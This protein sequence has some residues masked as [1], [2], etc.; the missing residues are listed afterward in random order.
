MG[1]DHAKHHAEHEKNADYAGHDAEHKE[2]AEVADHTDSEHHTDHHSSADSDGALETLFWARQDSTKMNFTE[3]EVTFM[4]DM[5]IHHSQALV[6]SELASKNGAG[7]A[8]S[9]LASRIINAQK[10]EIATMQ[11]WLRERGQ[12]VPVISIDGIIMT[13]EFEEPATS[14]TADHSSGHEMSHKTSKEEDHSGHSM[15][16][17]SMTKTDSS[18]LDGHGSSKSP[19]AGHTDHSD[20]VGMLSQAQLEELR[21]AKGAEFDRLFLTYMIQH[22]SGAL[23]MVEDLFKMDGAG[24]VPSTFRLASDIQ[25]DQT[26]EIARMNKMLEAMKK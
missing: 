23:V 16:G 15:D 14:M 20:M 24:Q 3:G 21:D 12:T 17:G 9:T 7:A 8:V 5:I 13:V 18:H 22:H 11:R 19:H 6:M 1:A 4:T 26:T 25:A 10:D 2:H